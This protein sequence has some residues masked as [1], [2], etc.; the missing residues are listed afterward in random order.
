MGIN[1]ISNIEGFIHLVSENSTWS[2]VTVG[3]VVNALGYRKNGGLEQLKQQWSYLVDCAKQA[4]PAVFM[5]SQCTMKLSAS[6]SKTEGTLYA[7]SKPPRKMR[8]GTPPG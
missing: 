2:Q 3:N 1:R 4:R 6:F 5:V 7:T 8:A